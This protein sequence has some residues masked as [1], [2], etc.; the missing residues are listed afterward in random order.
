MTEQNESMFS[1]LMHL[2]F[3]IF[4]QIIY[5]GQQI[6]ELD[7]LTL[8]TSAK[9]NVELGLMRVIHA[10]ARVISSTGNE[11]ETLLEG[12]LFDVQYVLIGWLYLR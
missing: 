5:F 11:D 6:E 9:T 7:G 10:I 3:F 4:F 2:I 1:L 12:V 8:N